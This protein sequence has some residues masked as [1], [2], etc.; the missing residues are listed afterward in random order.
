MNER[1]LETFTQHSSERRRG[2]EGGRERERGRRRRGREGG[3]ERRWEGREEEGERGTG[4]YNCLRE[5]TCR[6]DNWALT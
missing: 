3:R 6:Y 1:E 5:C 4:V 2:R